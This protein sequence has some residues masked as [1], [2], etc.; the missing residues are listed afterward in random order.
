MKTGDIILIPFPYSELS[1]IK[2]RPA[3]FIC[4]TSDKYRDLVASAISSVIT[5]SLGQN[6]IIVKPD[7][8]DNLRKISV[9][10]VDRIVTIGSSEMIAKIGSLYL[11]V[12]KRFKAVFKSLV[13]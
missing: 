7:N 13:D 8:Y 6:E 4:N 12:L 2:V 9:I 5:R 10:R 1:N 3:V 11:G